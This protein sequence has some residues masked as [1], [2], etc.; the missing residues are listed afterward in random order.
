MTTVVPP[1]RSKVAKISIS[2]PPALLAEIDQRAA[3]RGGTRS[4]VVRE[5]VEQSLRAERE[6]ADVA[7]WIRSYEAQPQ[8][9]DE[10][11]F[12]ELSLGAWEDLPWEEG[13]RSEEEPAETSR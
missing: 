6:R 12:A 3:Q 5:L 8:T 11:G 9:D 2:L 4:E 7:R 13:P 1:S 10:V